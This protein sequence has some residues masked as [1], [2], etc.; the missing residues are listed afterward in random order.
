M[1][2]LFSV[3]SAGALLPD[4]AAHAAEFL[5]LRA[6]LAELTA[7]LRDDEPSHLGGIADKKALEARMFEHLTWFSGQGLEVKGWAPLTLDFP[8][9]VDGR[10]VLLCW[11]EGE[12]AIGWWHL[13]EHGFAGRR[14]L[15]SN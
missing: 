7:A 2:E 11:L 3:E 4:V 9:V 12:T 5:T 10:T 14:P 13:P 1:S 6:D 15:R 8:A